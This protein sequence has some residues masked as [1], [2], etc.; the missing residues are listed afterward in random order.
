MDLSS[1]V[2]LVTGSGRGIGKSIALKLAEGGAA[3][4]IN[5]MADYAKDAVDEVKSMGVE[6]QFIKA[7]VTSSQ[8]VTDMVSEVIKDFGKID[9]LVNNAGITRDKL[10]ISMTDEDWDIVQNVNLKGTFLCTRAVLRPMMKQRWGRIINI[11][12]IVGIIGNI[13]QPNY[14]AS[15][16]GIIGLTKAISREMGSRQITCNAVAPGFIES[17]MTMKLPE[18]IKKEYIKRIPLGYFGMPE[19]IAETVVFL[20]SDKARYITGQV[21]CIDGG[22]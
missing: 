13:G 9:I 4:V 15:K 18:D 20:A 17:D 1:K 16:A 21:I 10:S 8:E 12:S 22:M 3:V 14:C 19:D 6:S 5:D 2:A 7:D 11:S